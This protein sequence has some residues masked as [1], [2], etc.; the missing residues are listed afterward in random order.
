MKRKIPTALLLV[1]SLVANVY[2]QSADCSCKDELTFLDGQIRK[3]APFKANKKAYEAAYTIA[4]KNTASA[5]SVFECQVLLNTLLIS[6]NDNHS[7][8]YSIDLG[9]TKEVKANPDA[10]AAFK[11]GNIYNTY[12]K[13]SIDL[14]SL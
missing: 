7:K 11:N 8:V 13:P 6:L 14:D 9:A 10:Y 5:K 12:P 3:K 2:S 4:L 1:I